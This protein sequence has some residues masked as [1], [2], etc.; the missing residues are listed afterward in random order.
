MDGIFFRAASGETIL[1]PDIKKSTALYGICTEPKLVHYSRFL[2]VISV[3][4]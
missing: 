2:L 1:L 4:R 3:N